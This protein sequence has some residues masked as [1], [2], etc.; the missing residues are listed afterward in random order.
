MDIFKDL[1]DLFGQGILYFL[2]VFS[3]VAVFESTRRLFLK[4]HSK[5]VFILATIGVFYILGSIGHSLFMSNLLSDLDKPKLESLKKG[6]PLPK[7]F[8]F[9]LPMAERAKRTNNIAK[10]NFKEFG[11]YIQVL[12]PEGKWQQ[13]VPTRKDIREREE[14]IAQKVELK[15]L[16]GEHKSA[17]K[18][19]FISFIVATIIGWVAAHPKCSREL[20]LGR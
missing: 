13:Y 3:L 6:L 15:H 1:S 12:N 19:W 20:W 9:G 16:I 2:N 8:A 18:Y 14:M 7:D 4:Q 11:E 17:V 10:L 5:Q